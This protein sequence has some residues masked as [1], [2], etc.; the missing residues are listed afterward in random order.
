MVL[1]F[2][3]GLCPVVPP[4]HPPPACFET[5]RFARLLSMTSILDG[6]RENPHPEERPKGASR[7]T[8][9]RYPTSISSPRRCRRGGAGAR[10]APRRRPPRPAPENIPA[11][12]GTPPPNP[13]T[14]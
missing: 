13:P 10:A 4:L 3:R 12:A 7:R 9:R 11:P 2:Q 1:P 5:A 8:H 6:I 14:P